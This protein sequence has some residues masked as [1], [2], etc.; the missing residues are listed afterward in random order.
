MR[1]ESIRRMADSIQV[2]DKID[3]KE[4]KKQNGPAVTIYM[5]L[6]H[7]SREG[8]RDNKDRLEFKNLSKKAEAELK[9]R[10]GKNA[11]TSITS[12]LEFILDREDLDF[13]LDDAEGLAF[14]LNS[15]NCYVYT[16]NGRPAPLV[17]VGEEF[18]ITPILGEVEY[19]HKGKAA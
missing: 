6:H 4:F 16:M 8:R 3:P 19:S 18:E 5:P 15:D 14:L 17:E 2:I 1:K 9:E 13:W 10:W 12:K 7:G 11:T